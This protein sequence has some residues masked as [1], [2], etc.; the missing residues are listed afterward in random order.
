MLTFRRVAAAAM[1]TSVAGLLAATPAFA[2]VT[3]NADKAVQGGYTR[4]AFRVPTESDTASTTK[5]EVVMPEDTPIA[6]VSTMPVPGW[7]VAVERKAPAKPLTAHGREIKLVV[8]KITWTATPAAVIR[9]GQ[10]QEF[11]VSMGTLPEA[12]TLTFKA[13]QYYSDKSIVRWIEVGNPADLERPAPVLTLAPK[14]STPGTP[15]VAAPAGKTATES[16][17]PLVLAVLG[18]IAGLAGLGI[19]ALA[20]QRS[21]RSA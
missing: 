11:P 14:D 6:S 19:G 9:P 17:T 1:V 18:L 20:L 8:S 2:H 7:V 16:K 10:F 4:V 3:V 5:V 21:R 12:P 15:A 13:L